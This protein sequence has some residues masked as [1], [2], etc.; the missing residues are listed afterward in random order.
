[1]NDP[2]RWCLCPRKI[3]GP[4][5]NCFKGC[6]GHM[7]RLWAIPATLSD[8]AWIQISWVKGTANKCSME[9]ASD[10]R[11]QIATE[12]NW[13]AF[14]F[15]EIYMWMIPFIKKN[16]N[17][18]NWRIKNSLMFYEL[19]IDINGISWRLKFFLN[20]LMLSSLKYIFLRTKTKWTTNQLGVKLVTYDGYIIKK[21]IFVGL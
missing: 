12:M 16:I 8:G 13:I 18:Q 4:I 6:W 10:A 17:F 14:R 20:F 3:H 2:A 9:C 15:M 7:G 11:L 5:L 19:V 1:M 21:Y